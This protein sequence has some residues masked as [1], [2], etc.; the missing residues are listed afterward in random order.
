MF[1]PANVLDVLKALLKIQ[2]CRQIRCIWSVTFNR[3]TGFA[4]LGVRS[5]SVFPPNHQPD[6]ARQ[7]VYYIILY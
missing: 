1:N 6:P 5:F 2:Y 4:V 7:L 3:L